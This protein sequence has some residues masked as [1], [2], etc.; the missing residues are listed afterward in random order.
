MLTYLQELHGGLERITDSIYRQYSQIPNTDAY[1]TLRAKMLQVHVEV[2]AVRMA[3]SEAI[4]AY[5]L[6]PDE[7]KAWRRRV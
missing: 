5:H 4:Q 7:E 1:Q 3:V 2:S 6:L